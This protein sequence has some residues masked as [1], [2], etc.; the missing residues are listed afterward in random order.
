MVVL[1]GVAGAC[2][3]IDF[4]P[5]A[6]APR[7][8]A[9]PCDLSAPFGTPSFVDGL[10]SGSGDITLRLQSNEL[11]GLFWSL[12]TGDAEIFEAHRPDRASPFTPTIATALSAP[13][14]LDID[15]TVAPDG[16][17]VVFGSNRT[18]SL[19]ALDLYEA[20]HDASGYQTPV[21]L[22]AL[23]TAS[24]DGEASWSPAESALYFYSD[25]SGFSHLYRAVRTGPAAYSAPTLMTDLMA[26]GEEFDP[27]PSADGLVLYFRS[28]RAG[29]PG[30]TDMYVT[31][32]SRI[33]DP[34]GPA[35]LVSELGSP[36]I[37]GPSFLSPD[38]CRIY[39]TSDRTG[40]PNLYVASH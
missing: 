2:G 29:G 23:N 4:V 38:Q 37:D 1:A 11:D 5:L 21:N 31:R 12:R 19:G 30:G 10:M 35:T 17:F 36:T 15:P 14:T 26:D 6:D 40:T 20:Q 33:T 8:D 18:D 39:F 16:S 34:F 27:A 22:T 24:T 25:R 3:R 7:P 32:R 13:V 9:G 28:S